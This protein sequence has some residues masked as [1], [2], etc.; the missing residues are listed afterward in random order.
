M[1]DGFEP[2]DHVLLTAVPARLT[3][4]Y[5][6]DGGVGEGCTRGMGRW[7]GPGGCYTGTHPVLPPGPIFNLILASGPYPR[8]NEQVSQVNDEVSQ[9][10]SRY[11]LRM[12]LQTG[13][14]MVL[15]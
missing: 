13:P 15:R 8:P 1:T 6:L 14:Q 11:G 7:E 4:V 3:A 5:M 12:T 2:H 9:I 10:G